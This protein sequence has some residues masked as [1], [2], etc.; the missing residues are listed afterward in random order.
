MSYYRKYTSVSDIKRKAEKQIK[1]LKKKD[2]NISPIIIEGRAIAKTWWAKAW[3]KNL[4]SYADYSNRIGRG[5]TYVRNGAVVDLRIKSGV[6]RAK[7]QGSRKKPYEVVVKIDL[8]AEENWDEILKIYSHKIESFESLVSG[9]F[10]EELEET[11]TVK[12]KGLFPS[13]DEIHFFCDCPDWA[14]MCKHV[15]ATLYGIGAKFDEDP[16]L[17]FVLRN[18]DF[19]ELLKKSIDQRMQDLLEKSNVK[20][21][22]ILE[23]DDVYSL[24]D[25]D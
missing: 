6:V 22:R 15:A 25:I 3:N 18:I 13:S 14:Y 21:G 8:M 7:I 5:K 17:F 24:F 4:E 16:T 2:P 10:P 9:K 11:F 1:D 20:T 23:S 19:S 12:G